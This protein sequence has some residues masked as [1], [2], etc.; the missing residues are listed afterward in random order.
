MSM[1][2]TPHYFLMNNRYKIAQ[3]INAPMILIVMRAS[4]M[5]M[6]I[7]SIQRLCISGAAETWEN[8]D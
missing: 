4:M 7:I 1:S 3:W 5:M 6:M 2:R 8:T